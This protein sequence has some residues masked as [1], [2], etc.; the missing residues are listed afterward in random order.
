[1]ARQLS[2]P[3]CGDEDAIRGSRE[4]GRIMLT[5]DTCQI[6]WDRESPVCAT[7]GG[8]RLL[9][10]TRRVESMGRGT[11]TSII[12]TVEVE[13]CETCDHEVLRAYTDHGQPLPAGY[14]PYATRHPERAD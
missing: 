7:C 11:Q 8:S 5:C 3:R 13:V 6:T 12:A 10:T 1:M 9:L 4:A 14:V 2:C